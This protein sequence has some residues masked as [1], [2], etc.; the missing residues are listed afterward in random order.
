MFQKGGKV[1]NKGILKEKLVGVKEVGEILS[2]SIYTVRELA[3][4]ME[5][6]HIKLGKSY[7]FT[8]KAIQ[9][10]INRVEINK[11]LFKVEYGGDNLL[12]TEEVAEILGCSIYKVRNLV[13]NS[14]LS[15]ID[16]GGNY[17]YRQEVITSY[18]QSK[19][20]AKVVTYIK[21]K[22]DLTDYSFLH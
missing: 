18:I 20:V 11:N 16:I 14:E 5:I 12:I 6:E 10:Y 17:R 22:I 3:K 2:V 21:P 1:R 13:K 15:Y 8:S 4:F 19:T 9:D 7:K